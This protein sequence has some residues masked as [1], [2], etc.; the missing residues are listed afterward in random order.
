M[1]EESE[2]RKID[3]LSY[4]S[5]KLYNK[6][7]L[8]YH[9]RYILKEP[10]KD[11]TQAFLTGNMVDVM[12]TDSEN[13]DDYFVISK[14][15][16]PTGQLYTFIN[17]VIE[18]GTVDKA[19]EK[20]KEE[21][22]GKLG[23]DLSKFVAKLDGEGADYY[24]ELLAFKGK[25]VITEKQ[26]DLAK[27]ICNKIINTKA[28]FYKGKE[29]IVYTKFVHLFKY[30]NVE[31]KC[32]IDEF[33]IDHAK[34]KVYLYD[35]KCTGQLDRFIWDSYL[36]LNYYIQASLYKY[37][38]QTW[39]D[40]NH[41]GYKVEPMAFKVADETNELDPLLYQTTNDHYDNGFNGF[42]VGSTYYK[43]ITQLLTELELSKS[44]NKWGISIYNYNNDGI[45][46]IPD[47]KQEL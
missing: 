41:P 30:N 26:K 12:M 4:S 33:T 15:T 6:S 7:P 34:K 28:F 46:Y 8:E 42:Y 37:A 14:T 22:G 11:K 23:S 1:K 35:Y 10:Q 45:V 38:L 32:E 13:F 24:N 40:V 21:N 31:M 29:P 17:N 36:K 43:G 44:L 27:K 2:Y 39:V 16:V 19:Y 9:K 5:L 3:R 47:F 20:L 18:L 25:T